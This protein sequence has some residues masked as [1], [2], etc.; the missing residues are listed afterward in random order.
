[1]V[2]PVVDTSSYVTVSAL[3]DLFQH[4][5]RARAVNKKMLY[6]LSF[7]GDADVFGQ[8]D[9]FRSVWCFRDFGSVILNT[10]ILFL[11]YVCIL[12]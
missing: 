6:W 4:V 11:I 3:V 12:Y 10:G 5:K 7:H 8:C 2:G 1:M 9:M